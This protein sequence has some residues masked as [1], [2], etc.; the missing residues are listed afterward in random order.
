MCFIEPHIG[1]VNSEYGYEAFSVSAYGTSIHGLLFRYYGPHSPSRAEAEVDRI[2]GEVA[3][4]LSSVAAHD[5]HEIPLVAADQDEPCIVKASRDF[6]PG[7]Y[8]FGSMCSDV[9]Q[10]WKLR[11]ASIRDDQV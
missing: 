9:D 7:T 3:R 10:R 5:E 11:M 4:V 2:L 8:S 1:E 6:E